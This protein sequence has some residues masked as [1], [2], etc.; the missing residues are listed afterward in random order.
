MNLDILEDMRLRLRLLTPFLDKRNRK[1]VYTDFQDEVVGVRVE[2][3]LAMPMPRM[4]SSQYAKK[5]K[6][7]LKNHHNHLV[8]HRLRSN[9]P[10][11]SRDLQGLEKTLQE[12]GE[13]E[14]ETLL[15]GLLERS[16]APS[17]V[18]FIRSMVGLDRRAAQAAFSDFLSDHSLTPDQIRFIEMIIDQLT[19][20]GFMEADALYEAPFTSLHSGGPDGL[21]AGKNNV[22][23]GIFQ[24]LDSTRPR[25]LDMA[26]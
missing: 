23:D 2:E 15:S 16:N 25:V 14:G 3:P 21:F 8:I 6:E 9:Q 5:V 18:H 19:A 26:G 24:A 11:T 17:L 1:V 20:R 10:L 13:E 12:I 7:Y 4:I 22:I